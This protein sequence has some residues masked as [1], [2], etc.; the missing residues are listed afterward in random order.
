MQKRNPTISDKGQSERFKEAARKV[1]IDEQ[2]DAF[3]RIVEEMSRQQ[4][5]PKDN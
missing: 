4:R 3:D 1:G 2:S 5:N